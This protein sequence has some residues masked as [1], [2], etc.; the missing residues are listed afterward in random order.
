MATSTI[1][2]ATTSG[3]LLSALGLLTGSYGLTKCVQSLLGEPASRLTIAAALLVGLVLSGV[4]FL[5]LVVAA[6]PF[7]DASTVAENPDDATG[8]PFRSNAA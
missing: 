2:S 8:H 4:G 6:D 3:Y 7:E 5:L 1:K